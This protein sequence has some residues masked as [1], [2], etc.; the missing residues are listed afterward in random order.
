MVKKE[1][2]AI[3]EIN[4]LSE[5]SYYLRITG[6]ICCSIM[7]TIGI[8]GAFWGKDGLRDILIGLGVLTVMMIMV[9]TMIFYANE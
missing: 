9:M 3:K 2:K 8:A 1:N 4:K 5:R 7:G 6:I